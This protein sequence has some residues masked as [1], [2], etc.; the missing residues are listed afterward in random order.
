MLSILQGL[1]SSRDPC[2]V[3]LCYVY[4]FILFFKKIFLWGG[5]N[6]CT[7]KLEKEKNF[8]RE[9]EL[10]FVHNSENELHQL[11]VCVCVKFVW[12][13]KIQLWSI[14]LYFKAKLKKN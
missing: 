10:I 7:S 12:V 13:Y 9:L 11:C 2:Y 3:M 5:L 14:I 4:F 8:G 6:F 1:S